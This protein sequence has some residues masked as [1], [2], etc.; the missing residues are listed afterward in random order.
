MAACSA[1]T[2]SSNSCQDSYSG[3]CTIKLVFIPVTKRDA[4]NPLLPIKRQL[5][6]GFRDMRIVMRII[7]LIPSR[8]RYSSAEE[9]H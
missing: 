1:H 5:E 9:S 8:F 7:D 4:L 3:L 6:R 2:S